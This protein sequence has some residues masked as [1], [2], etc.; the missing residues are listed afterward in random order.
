M[1][2]ISRITYFIFSCIF[3]SML[4]YLGR[5]QIL[6]YLIKPLTQIL[7][8]IIRIIK[9]IDQELF[10]NFLI[11]ILLL[12]LTNLIPGKGDQ[13]TLKKYTDSPKEDNRILYWKRIISTY[14]KNNENRTILETNLNQLQEAV[15]DIH[16]DED[17]KQIQLPPIKKIFWINLHSI[18][19]TSNFFAFF[20]EKL[21]INHNKLCKPIN[22][23]LKSIETSME[24]K[25]G[26]ITNKSSDS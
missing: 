9:T 19:P 23:F 4:I 15:T 11:F 8:L 5:S 6:E 24:I 13:I 25:N 10:W 17:F 2:N 12:L 14:T 26:N 3:L 21:F 20:T 16:E 18:F 7:W 1:R 22:D